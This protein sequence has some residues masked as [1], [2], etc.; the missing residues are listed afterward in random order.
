MSSSSS[1]SANDIDHAKSSVVF[2]KPVLTPG[3]SSWSIQLDLDV[4][5]A[6]KV[7]TSA[8][9]WIDM[10]GTYAGYVIAVNR[11]KVT[12][13]MVLTLIISP[14]QL[15]VQENAIFSAWREAALS[16]IRAAMA[17]IRSD[18]AASGRTDCTFHGNQL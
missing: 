2:R 12:Q 10:S 18:Y 5:D 11:T 6:C 9:R 14:R 3:Y 16:R 7:R 1:S 17:D 13:D 4:A 15:A 8:W